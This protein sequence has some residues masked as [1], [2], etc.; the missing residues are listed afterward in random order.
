MKKFII[1]AVA[2]TALNTV[3]AS[4]F[5]G[6]YAGVQA[7]INSAHSKLKN[8]KEYNITYGGQ[9]FLG[10]GFAGYGMG[11]GNCAYLGGEIY[12][13]P[14][15]IDIK[16][17]DKKYLKVSAR[18]PINFGIKTRLGYAV[19]PQ[20][21]IFLGLGL[22]CAKWTLKMQYSGNFTETDGT[23]KMVEK[24]YKRNKSTF[25][26][27]PSIGTEIFMTKNVFMRTEYTYIAP[28]AIRLEA[29]YPNGS[30]FTFKTQINQHRFTLGLGYKF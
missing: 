22:E 7:G 13:N 4:N 17:A 5:S 16:Y 6:F 12:I 14:T 21:M 25:A 9:A 24:E 18:N 8:G 10:G 30:R 28:I 3:S 29:K 1:A 20:A 27:A 11:I 2:A 15:S 26:F 19:N 23:V